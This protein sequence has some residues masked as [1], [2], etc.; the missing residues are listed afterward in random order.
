MD[1]KT[2]FFLGIS[3]L[4]LAVMLY[5]IGIDEV[6]EALK[7]AN[8]NYIIMAILIQFAIF[9]LYTLR[10]KV[11][12]DL[13]DIKTSIGK[14][15]PILLVG[16]AIN[17][18]TPSGRGGG[19]PVRAYILSKESGYPFEETFATVVADRALDTFPFVV[20]AAIT[21]AAMAIYFN[22]DTWLLI[23][24]VL[25]VIAIVAVL[26]VLIY[27]CINPGFG[28]RVEGWILS[29][30]RRFYKKNSDDLEMKI[31]DAVFGFQETMRLLI[32]NKK[33][34]SYTI[35]LS[36]FVWIMEILRVYFVFLAF[37]AQVN[38]IVI[39][40]VFIVACLVG[41]IPLLPGGLGAVDGMMI[42]FYSAAGI[43]TSVS[44]AATVI[45][46]LISFWM[47]TIMGLVILPH[48]GSSVL[49]KV[50]GSS[51]P[52]E[53]KESLEDDSKDDG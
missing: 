50:T 29:L 7:L 41:M 1:R 2:L 46:R 18:L 43:T 4:I 20:L 35:P 47:P 28:K 9:F 32:S 45:E 40:E 48:Y 37:G 36:F 34:L 27:M 39:G 52:D 24:M 30:V 25:A 11:L 13:A 10:W 8:I 3:I 44:A 38:L 49:D 5:F 12:N 6:V 51:S 14:T 23:V 31:H 16:L 17:N 26:I 42:L 22:V 15:L 53:I 21:I 19:E 33:V